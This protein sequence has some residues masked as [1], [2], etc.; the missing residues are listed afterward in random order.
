M[1]YEGE[2]KCSPFF[3][4]MNFNNTVFFNHGVNGVWH[5]GAQ[6]S[7]SNPNV[8]GKLKILFHYKL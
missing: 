5:S 1:Y 3:C 8:V 6:S 7:G 4:A 2:Q